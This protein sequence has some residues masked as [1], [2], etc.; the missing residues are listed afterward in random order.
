[1]EEMRYYLGIYYIQ[2]DNYDLAREEFN[3]ILVSSPRLAKSR[4]FIAMA[5]FFQGAFQEAIVQFQ[6][7]LTLNLDDVV[8]A[9]A[10]YSLATV[11]YSSRDY[12]NA[13]ATFK[14][15]IESY[16]DS[17]EARQAMVKLDIMERLG[18]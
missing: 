7:A 12:N 17:R 14:N 3:K 8:A 9:N 10:L 5:F 13:R 15:L 1:M 16:P 6:H 11:Y 18:L 4:Y 2:A